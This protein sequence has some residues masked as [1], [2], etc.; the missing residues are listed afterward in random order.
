MLLID[1][2]LAA[3][4][5]TPEATAI[6]HGDAPMSYRMLLACLSNAVRDLHG[7]GVR[8]G[9]VVALTMT[10]SPLHLVTFLALARLGAIV[11]PVS[12]VM[13]PAER[14]ALVRKFGATL[15]IADRVV[16]P[17]EGCA[18]L[19]VQGV[20]A[21][22]TETRLD[23][24]GF[25]PGPDDGLRI[26]LTSGTTG[27]PKGVMQTHGMF[28][29]RLDRLF[30][31]E[32]REPRVIPPNLAISIALNLALFALCEG[33][34]VVIPMGYANE[35]FFDAIRRHGVTLVP[36]APA[37]LAIMLQ[38]LPG[39]GPA[40][41][42]VTQ[43]RLLGATPSARLLD[44]ARERFSTHVY[45]PYAMGEVGTVS[46]ATPEMLARW[47]GTTGRVSPGAR[48][49]VVDAGGRAVAAGVTGEI[50]VAVD[51]MPGGYLGADAGDRTRF[52]D[53]WFHPGD[54]G[55][56]SAEG[57]V[58]VE[59]RTD[60]IINVGGRK[61]A[62]Q[63]AEA[64]LEEF[65]GVAEAAVFAVE[66]GVE[67]PR[68]AAAVVASGPLDLDALHRHAFARLEVVAPVRYFIVS[69]LPRND[70]GKLVR[71]GLAKIGDRPRFP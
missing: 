38:A 54:R 68:L 50:R 7:A 61:V 10:Q 71:E 57:L 11:L 63:F 31:G 52:R 47:P 45:L 43:L 2:I 44:L 20:R 17:V 32:P 12:T 39:G 59:G 53:G 13:G 56:V 30:C 66:A 65:P 22:G 62:P 29:V 14:A 8:P 26:A 48:L 25:A 28:S 27:L 58:F 42:S 36:I 3:V 60:E 21:R 6:V 16:P 55:H 9:Q 35:I 33:G 4:D 46:M 70:L 37:H 24:S 51:G 40:F 69:E 34:T 41:P 19:V 1:R 67:G 5:R 15:A 23:Y 49:E 18:S 64:V